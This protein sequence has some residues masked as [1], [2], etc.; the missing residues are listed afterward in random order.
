LSSSYCCQDHVSTEIDAKILVSKIPIYKDLVCDYEKQIEELHADSD[1]DL[2][3]NN[4]DHSGSVVS[5]DRN[6][7]KK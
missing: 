7:M 2:D 6:R 3:S 4:S 5:N 1:S